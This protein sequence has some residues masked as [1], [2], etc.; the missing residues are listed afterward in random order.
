MTSETNKSYPAKRESGTFVK[1]VSGNPGG[2]PKGSRNK[3][4]LLKESLELQLREQAAP[5][6]GKVLQKAVELALEGDRTMIKLLLELHM[7]K[8]VAEKENAV[9]KVEINI[10]TEQPKTRTINVIDAE[11]VPKN[12]QKAVQ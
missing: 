2:R 11:V 12:E 3:I 1:G 7:A 5:D 8:G 10:S 9:E 4:T 6:I